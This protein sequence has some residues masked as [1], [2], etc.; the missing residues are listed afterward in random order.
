MHASSPLR[1]LVSP[2][3]ARSHGRST[4]KY[5]GTMAERVEEDDDFL[6][7]DEMERPL[8]LNSNVPQS[9]VKHTPSR[10]HAIHSS[11]SSSSR[12]RLS[13]SS[14][15]GSS[16]SV[17]KNLTK[18]VTQA[19]GGTI[20]RFSSAPKNMK[21]SPVSIKAKEK[22]VERAWERDFDFDDD[23]N[24]DAGQTLGQSGARVTPALRPST[25]IPAVASKKGFIAMP[26]VSAPSP[27]HPKEESWDDLDGLA[28]GSG[29]TIRMRKQPGPDALDELDDLDAFGDGFEEDEATL[30]AG[31][32][33]RAQLPPSRAAK[34][35]A[36]SGDM[37]ATSSARMALCN[38]KGGTPAKAGV[39]D[40]DME[41]DFV[42]PLNL[43]SLTLVD[44]FNSRNT[45]LAS[46]AAKR[47]RPRTSTSTATSAV[48]A[49]WDSPHP[50]HRTGT[51]ASSRK[52]FWGDDTDSP[53]G[54]SDSITSATS[55]LSIHT[56]KDKSRELWDGEDQEE[57][58]EAGLVLPTNLFAGKGLQGV[59][60]EKTRVR[61]QEAK[62]AFAAQ[63]AQYGLK[64]ASP[65]GQRGII[66]GKVRH[67]R[68]A[69]DETTRTEN[70]SIEDGL[71]FED[72]GRELS[73]RQLER[74]R[75]TRTPLTGPGA[76]KRT[77]SGGSANGSNGGSW[78]RT[79]AQKEKERAWEKE[80]EQGWGR[81]TPLPRDVRDRKQSTIAGGLTPSMGAGWGNRSHSATVNTKESLRRADSPASFVPPNK[82][83]TSMNAINMAP[84]PPPA[85]TMVPT[86]PSR[87]RHQ[88]SHAALPSTP[89]S[90]L[91]RKRSLPSLAESANPL[92]PV[93]AGQSQSA[94][95]KGT[96]ASTAAG[97]GGHER[98][99]SSASRATGPTSSSLAK[100]R[101][102]PGVQN[103]FNLTT[104]GAGSASGSY[105]P[106]TATNRSAAGSGDRKE[107]SGVARYIAAGANARTY[108]G[109]ELDSIDDL[110][111]GGKSGSLRKR[112]YN[113][114]PAVA[115][116]AHG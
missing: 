71:V 107:M 78:G 110:E 97:A 103:I 53:R 104:T 102:T 28:V 15:I 87:L 42:L 39:P 55:S 95:V 9:H 88:K 10:G 30:K 20:T 50:S 98:W 93:V 54:F 63:V 66:G 76:G 69:T 32:T 65:L 12:I 94:F 72:P 2:S 85:S 6:L 67:R 34:A 82:P 24:D 8:V 89:S 90:G 36:S 111:V 100:M 11:G 45:A 23:G 19:P 3:P 116:W 13:P 73:K 84:P 37:L 113:S 79:A 74:A 57:D 91:S 101:S 47:T 64:P 1:Q 7:E 38:T 96:V 25:H 81:H 26:A 49:D 105:T 16:S 83:R 21:L 31:A 86:T 33:L 106:Y 5:P 14:S 115:Q 108:D 59:L 22:A 75:K 48:S 51:T 41:T 70:E 43:D 92:S 112:E 44:H 60:E 68:D 77:V 99:Y 40:E 17:I 27:T 56:P 52:G 58:M 80:R 61:E 29:I 4:S 62:A 46:Q 114:S 35:A 18:T 109:S